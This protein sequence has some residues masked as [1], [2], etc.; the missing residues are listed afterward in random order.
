MKT[1]MTRQM[2]DSIFEVMETMFYMTVEEDSRVVKNVFNLF[3]KDDVT[4]CRIAF[5]GNFSG[6]LYLLVSSGVLTEMTDSF[7]GEDLEKISDEHRDG[8]LKEALNMIAGNAL[9]KIDKQSYMGL[10]IPELINP[11][12]IGPVDTTIV[13]RTG[14]GP[15]VSMIGLTEASS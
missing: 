15:M 8:T 9:T 13:L 5:S 7:M 12:Q 4:I 14:D 1:M 6:T 11:S 2:T 3:D 10:G